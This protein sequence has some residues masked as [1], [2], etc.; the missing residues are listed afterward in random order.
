M[1]NR[2]TYLFGQMF[3][4]L[5]IGYSVFDYHYSSK[6]IYK[7][8]CM[9]GFGVILIMYIR[10]TFDVSEKTFGLRRGDRKILA[11]MRRLE[12][13]QSCEALTE[14]QLVHAESIVDIAKKRKI[15]YEEAIIDI[16]EYIDECEKK[17]KMN[18]EE[19]EIVEYKIR[20]LTDE[21]IRKV[22]FLEGILEDSSESES[23]NR[24]KK[25]NDLK[26]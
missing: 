15:S 24:M 7:S 9:I 1:R 23:Y 25:C 26:D 19:R 4:V 5:L 8:I 21:L 3:A 11:I 20:G 6:D 22:E 17:R 2:F 10:D 12:L 18:E 16:N 13:E 14:R